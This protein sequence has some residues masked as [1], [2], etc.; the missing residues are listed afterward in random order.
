[1]THQHYVGF[2]ATKFAANLCP[3]LNI[4]L[5]LIEFRGREEVRKKLIKK[6][7]VFS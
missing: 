7:T 4:I 6:L 5:S 1:L 3:K 2:A